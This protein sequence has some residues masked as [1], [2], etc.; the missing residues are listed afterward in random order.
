MT[1]QQFKQLM[2]VTYKNELFATE[3][4]VSSF[5]EFFDMWP[6]YFDSSTDLNNLSQDDIKEMTEILK[7]SKII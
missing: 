5:D 6:D 4:T 3:N 7:E 1:Y 2:S